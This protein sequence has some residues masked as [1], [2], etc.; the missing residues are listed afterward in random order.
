MW[1]IPDLY[2]K[3]ISGA[4]LNIRVKPVESGSERNSAVT[5]DI[6]KTRSGICEYHWAIGHMCYAASKLWNV[7]NFER[8][9]YR[10]MG[11][12]GYPDWYYQ[13]KT[14][15][16]DLWYRQLPSQT[17]QGTCRLLDKSWKSFYT[18]KRSGRISELNPPRF[19]NKICGS[20]ICRWGSYTNPSQTGYGCRFQR[21]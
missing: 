12:S 6:C 4:I 18:L 17:A 15:K 14:H 5:E 20:P 1:K 21:N 2:Q 10:E 16:S 3:N 19:K 11:L 13:K 8:Y 7:C 9:H